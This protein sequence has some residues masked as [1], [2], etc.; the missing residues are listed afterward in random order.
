MER[1]NAFSDGVFAI[2]I[3]ILV[4]E[5]H[6]P[7]ETSL[8]ALIELWPSAVSYAVSYLFLAIVWLNH[9]HLLRFASRA[10]GR[11]IWANFGHLFSVSLVPFD[12]AWVAGSR[13]SG[14]AV[15]CYAFIFGTVNLSYM[16]LCAETIDRQ[17]KDAIPGSARGF[18]RVRAALT[19]AIFGLATIAGWVYPIGGIALIVVC[20]MLYLQPGSARDAFEPTPP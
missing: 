4:L 6:P 14:L 2:V 16:A 15:A 1:L 13:L 12:T 5:L 19:L 10:T 18:M 17:A 3:T 7:H 9:H 20:L 8:R 11:L